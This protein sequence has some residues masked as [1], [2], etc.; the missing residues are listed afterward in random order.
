[1]T[2]SEL[3]ILPKKATASSRAATTRPCGFGMRRPDTRSGNRCASDDEGVSGLFPINKDR[4]LS[5]AET[6]QAATVRLWDA[7]TLSRIGEPLRLL[8]NW[9]VAWTEQ[10]DRIAAKTE[11]GAVQVFATDTMRP[12]GEPIRPEPS[13]GSN[14]VRTAGSW[15][16]ATTTGQSSCGIPAP[17]THRRTDRRATL[18][19]LSLEFSRDGHMVAVG[20]A[21]N[22]LRLWDTG[23]FQSVGDLM[24]R[25]LW[26]TA[27]LSVPT[28]GRLRPA[29]STAASD[30]G[31]PATNPSAP[32]SRVTTCSD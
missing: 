18:R 15:P 23:S 9:L 7:H 28:A 26:R 30:S 8:P 17:A 2:A 6:D 12:I 11:S 20:Y 24:R 21:D 27:R 5:V 14:S 13:R 4:L 32:C 22:T 19:S 16:P 31:M 3:A 29:A 25:P 1:M 10:A